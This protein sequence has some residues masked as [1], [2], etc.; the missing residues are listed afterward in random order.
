LFQPKEKVEELRMKATNP[1]AQ[2]AALAQS[3]PSFSI[4]S[5]ASPRLAVRPPSA[6]PAKASLF[7]GLDMHSSAGASPFKN[8]AAAITPKNSIKL[9][10]LRPDL[11]SSA[12]NGSAT[13]V[14]TPE[15]PLQ[16][17]AAASTPTW[18]GVIF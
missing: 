17:P 13:A 18:Y 12:G 5:A 1:A 14:Q 4:S 3:S 15:R 9:L 8:L 2:K 16:P 7:E 10:K 11:N 6:T